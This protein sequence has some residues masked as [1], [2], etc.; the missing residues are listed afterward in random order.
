MEQ[1]VN[2]RNRTPER[3]LLQWQLSTTAQSPAMVMPISDAED[4]DM[5]TCTTRPSG[6]H[7]QPLMVLTMEY[8]LFPDIKASGLY[9]RVI[10]G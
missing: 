1:N 6:P 10:M 2:A 3:T 7:R 9:E 8:L 4:G 5:L